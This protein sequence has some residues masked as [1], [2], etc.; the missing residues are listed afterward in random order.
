MSLE[1]LVGILFTIMCTLIVMYIKYDTDYV[2]L[3]KLRYILTVG[4]L[5]L[6]VLFNKAYNDKQEDDINLVIR[7][8]ENNTPLPP[9][10]NELVDKYEYHLTKTNGIKLS[11]G[12]YKPKRLVIK[13]E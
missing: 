9:Q 1:I 13:F 5:V 6:V 11:T 12:T 4:I 10:Y 8:L 7:S 2:Y 3:P